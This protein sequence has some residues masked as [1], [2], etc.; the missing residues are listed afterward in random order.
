MTDLAKLLPKDPLWDYCLYETPLLKSIAKDFEDDLRVYQQNRAYLE[1]KEKKLAP[2]VTKYP[3]EIPPLQPGG[4]LEFMVTSQNSVGFQ[5]LGDDDKLEVLERVIQ[6]HDYRAQLRQSGIIAEEWGTHQHCGDV[7]AVLRY[8]VK[9]YNEFDV[10]LVADPVRWDSV[11]HVMMLI[12]FEE[13]RKRAKQELEE[14]KQRL[15]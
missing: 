8:K 12:P 7:R 11:V 1:S 9:D 4:D 10:A 15:K 6:M 13:S 5:D 14:A 3:G 2:P